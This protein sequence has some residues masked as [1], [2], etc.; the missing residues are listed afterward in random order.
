MSLL[1]EHLHCCCKHTGSLLLVYICWC[2]FKL[3]GEYSSSN[4][5]SATTAV[6]APA[7]T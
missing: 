4:N 5:D 1:L 3:E 2:I 6:A 7:T